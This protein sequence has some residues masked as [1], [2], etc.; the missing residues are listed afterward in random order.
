MDIPVTTFSGVRYTKP[1]LDTT[2]E[3]ILDDIKTDKWKSR[4]EKCHVNLKNKDWLPVFTPT[5]TFNHRSIA[6]LEYYNGVICLDIDD[7]E[8][9]SELK[10]V[11]SQFDW[12][13]AAF[14]TPS[15]KGLKV[16]VLT[17]STIE[18]YKDTEEYVADLFFTSTGFKRDNRCKDIARIQYISW[19]PELYYNKNSKI[20]N[21]IVKEV[22]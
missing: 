13:H 7:V 20:L 19:D 18:T 9:P 16:I 4:I 22:A 21:K 15:G 12:T 8:N 11:I 14:I 5:G 17:D 10:I 3:N 1:K 6:G 2:L